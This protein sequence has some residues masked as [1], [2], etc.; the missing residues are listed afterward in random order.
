HIED[1][2]ILEYNQL[3]PL[4]KFTTLLSAF[5]FYVSFCPHFLFAFGNFHCCLQNAQMILHCLQ[6]TKE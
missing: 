4:G 3:S 5:V 2:A 1:D 6:N